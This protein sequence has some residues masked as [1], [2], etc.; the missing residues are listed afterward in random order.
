M[1]ADKQGQAGEAASAAAGAREAE[2][3]ESTQHPFRM[4]LR[5]VLDSAL[6]DDGLDEDDP[7]APEPTAR[8]DR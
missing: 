8:S 5:N 2:T 6:W 1:Q 4:L 3:P 7:L